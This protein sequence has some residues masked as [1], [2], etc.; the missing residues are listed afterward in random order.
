MDEL[1]GNWCWQ[2]TAA[3]E[4]GPGSRLQAGPGSATPSSRGA[5][6]NHGNSASHSWWTLRLCQGGSNFL[7]ALGGAGDDTQTWNDPRGMLLEAGQNSGKI[8][9]NVRL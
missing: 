1:S 8:S 2:E 3:W 4:T 7:L 5:L 6:C 9:A